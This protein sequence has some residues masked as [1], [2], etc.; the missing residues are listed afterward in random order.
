MAT[1]NNL[2]RNSLLVSS[3]AFKN[4]KIKIKAEYVASGKAHKVQKQCS[5]AYSI[6]ENACISGSVIHFVDI[7]S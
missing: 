4:M 3:S 6:D 1:I 5:D 2:Y 7:S